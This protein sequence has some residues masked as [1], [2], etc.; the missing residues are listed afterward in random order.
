[1]FGI[2][3]SVWR[4]TN[5]FHSIPMEA[6]NAAHKIRA[7]PTSILGLV[8]V[9]VAILILSG[10]IGRSQKAATPEEQA[11]RQTNAE[12]PREREKDTGRAL[13]KPAVSNASG[14]TVSR[15]GQDRLETRG[16]RGDH[17]PEHI[18]DR[19]AERGEGRGP[20]RK[21]LRGNEPVAGSSSGRETGSQQSEESTARRLAIKLAAELPSI[22]RM[23]ICHAVQDEE[24]WITLYQDSDSFYDL[25]QFIWSVGMDKPEPFLVVKRVS[26]ERVESH[27]TEKDPGRVCSAVTQVPKG[28]WL[29]SLADASSGSGMTTDSE[30]A[31][32]KTGELARQSNKSPGP[33]PD[34]SADD[35]TGT[36]RVKPS[37]RRDVPPHP[38]PAP[39]SQAGHESIPPVK[40]VPQQA[41]LKAPVQRSA[42]RTPQTAAGQ[43]PELSRAAPKRRD[44]QPAA[45][46]K[47]AVQQPKPIEKSSTKSVSS[48]QPK[49]GTES[50]GPSASRLARRTPG[51]EPVKSVATDLSR[52]PDASARGSDKT[53]ETSAGLMVRPGDGAASAGKKRDRSRAS[54]RS[55][56]SVFVYGTQMNHPDFLAWLDAHGYDSA[57]V[58]DAN[59]ASLDGYD[60][61]WNY[62]SASRDS[63]AVN[64]EPKKNSKIW[65]LLIECDDPLLKAFDRRE[66]H[67]RAYDRGENRV[68]VTRLEDG[69]TVFAW[70]YRAHPNQAGR[71]DVWPTKAY[72]A[73][74]VEAAT[75][76][77]FPRAYV[78]K[79]RAWPTK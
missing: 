17:L 31:P 24:W 57:M 7:T 76:W 73:K 62:Y 23:R 18:A 14:Q 12:E 35:K 34:R 11:V 8:G 70:V 77:G 6:Q 28:G 52:P 1:M 42:A 16:N 13:S 58:R 69:K 39:V 25:K 50:D 75:F 4:F 43:R 63:G 10:C 20:G 21:V 68:P 79:I 5:K 48:G 29:S 67:P 71:R 61:V 47:S 55:T 65:G 51:P 33:A 2:P 9:S 37:E 3:H 54:E 15:R 27:F 74:V 40:T 26:K 60:F 30:K 59:P 19:P 41:A 44:A 53:T 72:K 78:D 22:E 49:S 46:G 56:Y 45:S 32:A 66:G 38:G 36:S 64:L